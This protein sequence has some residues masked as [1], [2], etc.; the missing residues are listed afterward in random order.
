MPTSASVVIFCVLL[1]L[2]LFLWVGQ[3][4]NLNQINASDAAGNALSDAFAVLLALAEWGLLAALL[5]MGGIKGEMPG[6]AAILAYVLHP[7]SCAAA[8]ATGSLMRGSA[9]TTIPGLIVVPV[10]APLAIAAFASWAFF[11]AFRGAIPA[12]AAGSAWGAVL[13]LAIL[14]WPFLAARSRQTTTRR[15]ANEIQSQATEK[16]ASAAARQENLK[17]L[18]ALDPDTALWKWMEFTDPEKGVREEAYAAIHKLERRQSDA[19]Q[20]ASSGLT[21]PLLDLPNLNLEPTPPLVRAHKD[22]LLELVRRIRRPD[23]GSVQYSWIASEIDSYLPSIQWM[24]ER[25]CGCA[26]EVAGLETEIRT[27]QDSRGRAAAVAAL[28]KARAADKK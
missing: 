18:E 6:W 2:T 12:G 1:A 27:Y 23:A 14:P 13:L 5:L 7:A 20:M 21:L 22:Y 25:H 9:G 16:V 4:A 3:I 28:E 10:V 24:A 11:P 19:E 17:K 15:A 26:A 8:I